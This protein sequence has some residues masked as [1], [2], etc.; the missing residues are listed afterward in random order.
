MIKNK[1]I[2]DIRGK[3]YQTVGRRVALL[4]ENHKDHSIMTELIHNQDKA[5]IIKAT[6]INEKNIIVATGHAEEI[7]GS[8]NINKTSALEN[9]ETSA[10]GRAL[11]MFGIQGEEFDIP[12]ANEM[13]HALAG[14]SPDTP[15][16]SVS[17]E[18][19]KPMVINDPSDPVIDFE[20]GSK[21]KKISELPKKQQKAMLKHLTEKGGEAKFIKALNDALGNVTT[22]SIPFQSSQFP[23]DNDL[24]IPWVVVSSPALLIASNTF[25]RPPRLSAALAIG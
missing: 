22:D 20:C 25:I 10:V 1:G 11:A 7:R 4:R 2:V 15:P 23:S 9:A 21:G 14:Q 5:V 18:N 24:S 16:R 17:K 3:K 13:V 19:L 6:I 8:N 12:T